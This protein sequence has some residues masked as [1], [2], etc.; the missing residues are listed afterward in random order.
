[1]TVPRLMLMSLAA[2]ADIIFDTLMMSV[3]ARGRVLIRRVLGERNWRKQKCADEQCRQHPSENM[4]QP[5]LHHERTLI[6]SA[7]SDQY[8]R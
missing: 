5:G 6:R 7:L 3:T 1:M 2:M 4:S 8:W